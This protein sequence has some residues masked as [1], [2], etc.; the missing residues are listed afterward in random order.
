MP[1]ATLPEQFGR[2]R[3]LKQ[4]GKGGMGAVYL[5]EDTQLGRRVALK[6]P[7]IASDAG[8]SM[9][10]R[11]D[12]EAR[13]AATLNHPN[14]C[15]VYDVGTHNGIPFLTMAYIE[16]QTL[17][18]MVK[19]G[20]PLPQV[21]AASIVHTL[22]LALAEAHRR[23]VVHRDLKLA[24]VMMNER[25]EPVIMDFGLARL[26]GANAA[27]LTGSGALL[28]TPSY[29]P[30]EQVNGDVRAIGPACDIY[31][32][33]VILY[34]LLTGHLPFEGSVGAVLGQILTQAPQPPSAHRPD[35]DRRLEAICLKAMQKE[36][37][38]RYASMTEFAKALSG[39]LQP[40]PPPIAVAA[41]ARPAVLAKPSPG[42]EHPDPRLETVVDGKAKPERGGATR[43][44]QS[45]RA[46]QGPTV[47]VQ[48][49]GRS[50]GAGVRLG[51]GIGAAIGSVVVLGALVVGLLLWA[52]RPPAEPNDK[53]KQALD[54]A[55]VNEVAG[56]DKEKGVAPKDKQGPV[57]A[58]DDVIGE[59]KFVKVKKG[60]F[61]MGGGSVESPA[62]KPV[63]I[64][65]DFEL[66][67]YT[68]TQGQWEA[69]MGAGSNPSYFSRQGE[70]SAKVADFSDADL[71]RFP[72]EKVSWNAV[73]EYLEKLNEWERGKGYAYRLPKEAEWEYACRGGSTATQQECAFDFYFAKPTNDLSSD[74]AN[75][76]GEFPAGKAAKGKYVGRTMR[77]GQ[78]QPNKLGL[79]DMHGNVCQW[80]EDLY[81]SV[82]VY[83][84][85]GWSYT[86]LHC[87]AVGRSWLAQSARDYDLGFRLARVP[88]GG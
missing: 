76:N 40:A 29:M 14:I 44:T 86:G 65:K 9:L 51:C 37:A 78:Y 16:G 39:Y 28:G 67:A 61:W 30:P 59:M 24:N 45:G 31:S 18:E 46:T 36:I 66:A 54:K 7:H 55:S 4:L 87:R 43:P 8:P 60:S 10:Q 21:A 17:A 15:P 42:R 11:F 38:A 2:Y 22:A 62:T 47:L 49:D 53:G 85:G 32:L 58:V 26:V 57:V 77:V 3:I 6:V 1:A 82:R 69:A 80:C 75:F 72:V 13:A 33:G 68:V 50:S 12:R 63:T 34:E 83:R 73:Q 23:G 35:L 84:G 74:Q 64:G 70:G 81:G 52:A 41:P 5:A 20:K 71:K 25:G 48:R 79:Y 19:K 27:H 88:S 56:L